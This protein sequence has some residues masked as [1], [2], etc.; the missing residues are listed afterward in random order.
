MG[1]AALGVPTSK[2]NGNIAA[3]GSR[4]TVHY[5]HTY[6]GTYMYLIAAKAGG[7]SQAPRF[8]GRHRI[9]GALS[10]DDI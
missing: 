6:L 7:D 1:A 10:P 4:E 2:H 3:Q 9:T 5:L 8:Q